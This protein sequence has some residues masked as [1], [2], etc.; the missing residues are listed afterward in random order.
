MKLHKTLITLFLSLTCF[1]CSSEDNQGIDI[2]DKILAYKALD[3]DSTIQIDTLNDLNTITNYDDAIIYISQYGCHSCEEL[4][5]SILDYISNTRNIIYQVDINLYMEAYNNSD[6]KTGPYAFHYPKITSTPS[7]LFY[8]NGDLIN[9]HSDYISPDSFASVIKDYVIEVNYI[10]LNS[11]KKNNSN[12]SLYHYDED[13]DLIFST[14]KLDSFIT[15]NK[16]VVLFTWRQCSDCAEF[17]RLILEPFLLKSTKPVYFY[18]TTSYYNFRYSED[19]NEQSI[20]SKKWN[21]FCEY[22]NLDQ[23][24]F[25]DNFNNNAG[26]TPTLVNFSNNEICVFRNDR[27]YVRTADGFLKYQTAFFPEVQSITSKSKVEIGDTTSSDYQKAIR[28]LN[29]QAL[30]IEISL[31][32]DF[33]ENNV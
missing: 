31:C 28:E 16:K 9:V 24:S 4:Y 26:V 30:P 32:N 10:S 13:A 29:E 7:F 17:K 3:I 11:F 20:G 14:D 5:P 2:G 25:K 1:G 18:E 12:Y 15:E 22:Y 19:A 27:G 6:N 23:Y 33:L 21:D 8:R